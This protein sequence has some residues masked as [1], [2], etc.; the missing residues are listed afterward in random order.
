MMDEQSLKLIEEQMI[1][2]AYQQNVETFTKLIMTVVKVFTD[3]ALSGR[4]YMPTH[5]E[6]QGLYDVSGIFLHTIF[7]Q[8]KIPGSNKKVVV[9]IHKWDSVQT[10]YSYISNTIERY[11]KIKG[12]EPN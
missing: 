4:S 9:P 10:V 11:E 8:M 7:I 3:Q 1:Q 6:F 2:D 12:C 5:A